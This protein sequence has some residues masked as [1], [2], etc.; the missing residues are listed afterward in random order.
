MMA[1]V[2]SIMTL[3]MYAFLV[4]VLVGASLAPFFNIRK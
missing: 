3:L 4:L 1:L 2:Q